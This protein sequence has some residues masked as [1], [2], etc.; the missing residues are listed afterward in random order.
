MSSFLPNLSIGSFSLFGPA[1]ESGAGESQAAAAAVP[2]DVSA[3]GRDSVEVSV[4]VASPTPAAN[5]SVLGRAKDVVSDPHNCCRMSVQWEAQ[6]R[7]RPVSKWNVI[8]LRGVSIFAC[9]LGVVCVYLAIL[10]LAEDLDLGS[11]ALVF[12][13]FGCS[14]VGIGVFGVF[15]SVRHAWML[16]YLFLMVIIWLAAIWLTLFV[17]SSFDAMLHK[18]HHGALAGGLWDRMVQRADA[19]GDSPA[20]TLLRTHHCGKVF[21]EAQQWQRSK[22]ACW[23]ALTAFINE[24]LHLWLWDDVMY[25]GLAV[26]VGGTASSYGVVGGRLAVE[27][28]MDGLRFLQLAVALLCAAAIAYW[29]EILQLGAG[30]LLRALVFIASI[31]LCILPF[32]AHTGTEP[33]RARPPR[34]ARRHARPT[35]LRPTRLDS[36]DDPT[37]SINPTTG[38]LRPRIGLR[39]SVVCYGAIAA[40]AAIA[41]Y[42]CLS[43]G[44]NGSGLLHM[45]HTEFGQ[46]CPVECQLELQRELSGD[47]PAPPPP[48]LPAG[49]NASDPV[50]VAQAQAVAEAAT[51]QREVLTPCEMGEIQHLFLA[52]TAGGLR[53]LGW[54]LLVVAEVEAVQ[55]ACCFY[56][57]AKT[58]Q[59]RQSRLASPY[60]EPSI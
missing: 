43:T 11:W 58:V 32:C 18:L 52:R 34:A 51:G 35:R 39:G 25:G 24:E 26:L 8:G 59:R 17:A 15:A 4:D 19:G 9:L 29:F 6:L 33:R 20:L 16:L 44:G 1:N 27:V 46:M 50:A 48:P 42:S 23:N 45:V 56:K 36:L 37:T 60:R 38:L 2:A 31:L 53:A 30:G 28:V 41:S 49:V 21:S 54:L 55:C 13:V 14:L 57:R 10:C 22:P 47:C 5:S 3:I 7:Q 40:C 12:F